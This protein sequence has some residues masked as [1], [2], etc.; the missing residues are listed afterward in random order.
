[1]TVRDVKKVMGDERGVLDYL[2]DMRDLSALVVDL[3]YS[4][5]LLDDKEL[6]KDVIELENRIDQLKTEVQ[7]KTILSRL[8]PEEAE[9]MLAVLRL[10]ENTEQISDR[11]RAIAEIV[12]HGMKKHPIIKEALMSGETG[13]Y[14][15]QV[16]PNAALVGKRLEE[17]NLIEAAGMQLLAIKKKDGW[18]YMPTDAQKIEGG[19][20]LLITGPR[21]NKKL[22]DKLLRK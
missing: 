11:A 16:N 1:M 6:A 18:H 22:L 3:A 14:K 9:G 13:I 4:A 15:E 10:A 19:D 2:I 20:S 5:V 8:P 17:L 21:D 12:L 7:L